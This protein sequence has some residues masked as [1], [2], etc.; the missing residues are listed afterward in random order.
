[1]RL[2]SF[3]LFLTALITLRAYAAGPLIEGK[4]GYFQPA[5]GILK[6]IYGK[7]W[8]NYQFEISQGL[9]KSQRGWKNIYLWGSVNY[10]TKT[11]RSLGG[12][13]KTN[14]RILPLSAGFKLVCPL[15][16]S[17]DMYFSGGARY[18]FLYI[19]NEVD[20]VLKKVRNNGLGGVFSIGTLIHPRPHFFIDLFADYSIKEFNF[21]KERPTVKRYKLQVG[22]LT[23][24][25]GIGV[26]F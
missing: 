10:V 19:D 9:S 26:N 1:M 6:E 15:M 21:H 23:V 18:F 4:I 2:L 8:T 5:S 7:G 20:F 11:G 14:I 12:H 3:F 13:D 25:A 16:S 24:G 17:L 22:G